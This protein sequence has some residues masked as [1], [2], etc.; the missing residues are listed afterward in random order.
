LKKL[1]ADASRCDQLTCDSQPANQ[2]ISR[3]LDVAESP[4]ESY[5]THVE[6]GRWPLALNLKYI[7]GTMRIGF[8]GREKATVLTLAGRYALPLTRRYSLDSHINF[9]KFGDELAR[10]HYW[11][12]NAG[13]TYHI[14]N[15]LTQTFTFGYENS[16]AGQQVYKE[17][18]DAYFVSLGG[19]DETINF[20]IAHRNQ[21]IKD[22]A[23]PSS[24]DKWQF[25]IQID[26][27]QLGKLAYTAAMW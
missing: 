20:K 19:L 22:Y 24:R 16:F 4:I 8:D 10:D 21:D 26:L 2:A 14:K 12:V 9:H 5:L 25:Q 27:I 1:Q 3:L 6:T 17:E 13:M 11:S 18:L 7:S 15:M 23:G